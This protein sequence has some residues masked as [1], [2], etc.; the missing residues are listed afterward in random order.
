[1][2]DVTLPFTFVCWSPVVEKSFTRG[3]LEAFCVVT[4]IVLSD[5][6]Q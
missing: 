1:M 2:F 3:N 6:E 4:A 5:T